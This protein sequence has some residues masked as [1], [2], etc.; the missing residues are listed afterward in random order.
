MCQ[1]KVNCEDTRYSPKRV[2]LG[3]KNGKRPGNPAFY[4]SL[5]AKPPSTAQLWEQGSETPLRKP[6]GVSQ[7]FT[8]PCS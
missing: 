2:D 1:K 6:V 5:K 7:R 3:Q 4:H 8:Q